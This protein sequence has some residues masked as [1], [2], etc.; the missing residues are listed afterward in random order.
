MVKWI[1]EFKTWFICTVIQKLY[2]FMHILFQSL[3]T[4]AHESNGWNPMILLIT[5]VMCKWQETDFFEK[6]FIFYWETVE[7]HI[8]QDGS[9]YARSGQLVQ[10]GR[11]WHWQLD[12]QALLQSISPSLHDRSNCRNCDTILWWPNQVEGL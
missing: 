1:F 8:T 11:N 12:V 3:E 7:K 5:R 6:I 4:I 9:S 10:V 2:I